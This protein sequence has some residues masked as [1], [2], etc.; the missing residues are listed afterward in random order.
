MQCKDILIQWLSNAYAQEN[1]ILDV[2]NEH[3]R[4]LPEESKIRSEIEHHI[5]ETQTQA[6]RL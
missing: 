6:D 1:T 3:L 4:I 5:E 2:L